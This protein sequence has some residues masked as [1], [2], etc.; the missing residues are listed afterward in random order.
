MGC[1]SSFGDKYVVKVSP[2]PTTVVPDW[3][4]TKSSEK[5]KAGITKKK[6]QRVQPV[7]EIKFSNLSFSD[8]EFSSTIGKGM[9]GRVYLS[10]H[11]KSGKYFA[12]KRMQ[13]AEIVRRRNI[14]H[15]KAEINLLSAA[16][17]P[18]VISMCVSFFP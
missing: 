13:K 11:K 5:R 15:V 2:A 1:G 4:A 7:N 10:R 6:G 14:E 12:L 16:N 18:F 9:V 8:F 17:S 3:I